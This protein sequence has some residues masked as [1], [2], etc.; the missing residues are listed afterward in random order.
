MEESHHTTEA[1]DT[2]ETVGEVNTSACH[3]RSSEGGL[4]LKM[5]KTD[6][7]VAMTHRSEST[8]AMTQRSSL[9]GNQ[10]QQQQQFLGN[11]GSTCSSALTRTSEKWSSTKQHAPDKGPN[12][13]GWSGLS[14]DNSGTKD[15]TVHGEEGR[16]IAP[17]SRSDE[18]LFDLCFTEPIK[19]P[20]QRHQ[21]QNNQSA[22]TVTTS[23]F[24]SKRHP[25]FLVQIPKKKYDMRGAATRDRAPHTAVPSARQCQLCRAVQYNREHSVRAV[26]QVVLLGFTLDVRD[27][28]AIG[29]VLSVWTALKRIELVDN[30]KFVI[31]T[32]EL[33][34]QIRLIT[35]CRA[36]QLFV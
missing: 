1:M 8:I 33:S 17:P 36:R 26:T 15:A 11:T 7:T 6:N 30:C 32:F 21:N 9:P 31:S 25:Q 4:P 18:D 20:Q 12:T 22:S 35:E 28:V 2:Q 19:R 10:P 5:A 14:L 29:E 13:S 3:S 27:C 34:P 16:N 24:P 23:K